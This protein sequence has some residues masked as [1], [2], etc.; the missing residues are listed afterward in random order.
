MKT[1]QFEMTAVIANDYIPLFAFQQAII[2]DEVIG[3]YNKPSREDCL[4][5]ANT[6]KNIRDAFEMA[7]NPRKININGRNFIIAKG[8]FLSES[9]ETLMIC[10]MKKEHFLNP[11]V[12]NFS[13]Y[14]SLGKSTFSYSNY[15]LFYSTSFFTDP[16]LSALNRRLQKEMLQF[17]YEK[18]IEVRMLPS[19]EI[20]KNT[21]AKLFEVKKTKSLTQLEAYM[22]QVLPNFLHNGGEDTFIEQ[23]FEPVVYEHEEE[24]SVEQE[25]LLYDSEAQPEEEFDDDEIWDDDLEANNELAAELAELAAEAAQF[26][27]PLDPPTVNTEDWEEAEQA[28]EE[29]E[30]QVDEEAV[31][32]PSLVERL[33]QYNLREAQAWQAST[34]PAHTGESLDLQQEIVREQRR[35]QIEQDFALISLHNTLNPSLP[36]IELIDDT[37]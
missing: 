35:A 22:A 30:R 12:D 2:H 14:Y 31:D 6:I 3:Y 20:E 36:A 21:F 8:V 11:S 33:I 17:C 28:V 10:S 19:S 37:E 13:D 4:V 1:S 34:N 25:A 24:L 23:D 7:H 18:G 32:N 29:L 5:K 27:Q 15:V 9:G 26:D 16:S